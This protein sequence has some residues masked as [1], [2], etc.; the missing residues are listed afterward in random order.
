MSWGRVQYNSFRRTIA[1]GSKCTRF[2]HSLERN[3]GGRNGCRNRKLFSGLR[4]LVSLIG[5]A[6]IL[7]FYF[8][9][10]RSMLELVEPEVM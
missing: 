2:E 3:I 1:F 6:T 8:F 7:R 9:N 4:A 10:P 5:Q